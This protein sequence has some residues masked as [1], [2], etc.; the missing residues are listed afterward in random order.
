MARK[1]NIAVIG[2]GRMGSVHVRNIARYIP[3]ANLVA[4]CDL[5]LE[6]AQTVADECG[7][8]RV[9]QDYHELLA[10]KDLEAILIA[11]STNTHA[12]IMKDVA[13]AGKHIFCEKPLALDLREIDEA[14]REVEKAGVKLQV[15]FNRRFDKSFQKVH[16]IVCSGEI[17][18]PC[19]LRI[20]S[21]DPEVPAM[22]FMRVSGGMFLDM[23]I[24][25]FDMAR[26]QVGEIEEVY[27]IGG[28]LVE[29][30]LN[31][32]GDIDTNVITLKFANGAVGTIDNSRKAVYGYDQRLEVFCSNGTALAEN[33][34]E[35]V[36]V[37]GNPEGFHSARIPHFFMNRYASCY[38]EEVRQFVECVSEDIPT[39]ITGKDGRAAVVLGYA[40][41]KSLRE[42]RPVKVSEI[43]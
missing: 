37:K 14:L 7:I 30:A 26:F 13:A 15:G 6:V 10:D 3:E 9:V 35:N 2:T 4:I 24:H 33:E 41:G 43:G 19:I 1:V 32:F 20:T 12:F 36:A 18:H 5:R 8:Q 11:T 31:E 40:A 29:P 27:A 17:G 42:N 39:P 28:V 25:D 38:V 23:S 34:K 16:E 22:E 21:R